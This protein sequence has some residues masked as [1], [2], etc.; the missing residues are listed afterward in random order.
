M[1]MIPTLG[2]IVIYRLKQEDADAI[3]RRRNPDQGAPAV[4]ENWP[5]GAQ[6]HMGNMAHR[7]DEFPALIVR[8]WGLTEGA[9]VQLQV[10]LDGNDVFWATSVVEG[11]EN[12]MWRSPIRPW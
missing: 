3:N 8:L 6:R 2:R 10:F 11:E 1:D 4:S 9:A 5:P 12:G 7:G